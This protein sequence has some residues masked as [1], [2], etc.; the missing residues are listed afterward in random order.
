LILAD[1]FHIF[2]DL[3]EIVMRRNELI[4]PR[5]G[6]EIPIKPDKNEES[7]K[8]DPKSDLGEMPNQYSHAP[9]H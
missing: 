3:Q 6:T 1:P 7:P 9:K 5:A 8:H 4:L 2:S